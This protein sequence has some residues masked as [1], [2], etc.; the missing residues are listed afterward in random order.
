MPILAC[1]LCPGCIA[2]YAKVLSA[3]GIGVA[4][5]ETQHLWLLLGCIAF[6]LGFGV[7]ELRVTRRYGPL[8]LT[9]SGCAVFLVVHAFGEDVGLA[10]LSWLGVALLVAGAVWG[11]RVRLGHRRDRARSLP[12]RSS[13]MRADPVGP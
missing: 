13:P 5:S 10:G 4:L 6:S 1:A 7:R 3:L 2:T 11:H 9:T 12:A 8:L